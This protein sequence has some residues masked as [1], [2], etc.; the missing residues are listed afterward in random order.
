M[1]LSQALGMRVEGGKKPKCQK[2]GRC[3]HFRERNGQKEQCNYL[4]K[5]NLCLLYGRPER[6]KICSEFYC[7]KA[8]GIDLSKYKVDRD[9]H[10]VKAPSR[11]TGRDLP[12]HAFTKESDNDEPQK[13]FKR[14]NKRSI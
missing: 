1:R 12:N 11:K 3:C 10:P 14:S 13:V 8:L 2:C 6:P 7:A 4:S 5:K 9:I